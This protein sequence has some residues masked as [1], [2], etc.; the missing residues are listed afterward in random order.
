MKKIFVIL[1]TIYISF[2]NAISLRE[3]YQN[4]PASENFDKYLSLEN[5]ETYTGGLIIGQLLNIETFELDGSDGE[6]VKIVGNGAILDLQGEEISISYCDNVLEISDC[7]IINGSIRFRGIATD[8][9][10]VFP[11]GNISYN[12]FYNCHDYAVR[13]QGCAEGITIE[14]NIAVNSVDTGRDFVYVSGASTDWLPTGVNYALSGQVGLYGTPEVIDNFS[15]FTRE[16][17]NSDLLKH[18]TGL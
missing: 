15:Y 10:T 11:T 7:V 4:A 5:G 18:F 17:F 8:D 14:R 9:I 2:L 1:V 13:L 6:N 12:T 3:F 16:N